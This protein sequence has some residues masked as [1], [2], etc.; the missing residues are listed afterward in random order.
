MLGGNFSLRV[1]NHWHRLPREVVDT[2]SLEVLKA[3]LDGTQ[4]A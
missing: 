3:W 1:V 4:V 2:Q